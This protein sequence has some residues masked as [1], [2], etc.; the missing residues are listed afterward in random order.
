VLALIALHFSD[1]FGH[2]LAFKNL[3]AIVRMGPPLVPQLS[4][5][6]SSP[7]GGQPPR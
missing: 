1:T 5:T 6:H 7:P 2:P 4:A 3:K